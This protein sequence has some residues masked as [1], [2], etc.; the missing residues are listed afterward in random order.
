MT[1]SL[2]SKLLAQRALFQ[3]LQSSKK[4]SKLQAGFTLIELLVVIVIIGILAAIAIPNFLNQRNKA[5]DASA[6]AWASGQARSCAASVA[7]D[8]AAGFQATAA[9]SMGDSGVV[10]TAPAS[11][12]GGSAWVG[13][14]K[15][16]TVGSGGTVTITQ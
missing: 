11:C 12:V 8:D 15:T 9:P 2:Q 4:R 5:Y 13:G 1:S 7:G 3:R 16:W 10:V 14:G 6:E